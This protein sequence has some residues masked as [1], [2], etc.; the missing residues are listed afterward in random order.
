MNHITDEQLERRNVYQGV[1]DASEDGE[2]LGTV[3]KFK[4][5][6]QASSETSSRRQ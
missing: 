2:V 1:G 5:K 6:M 4:T 3:M